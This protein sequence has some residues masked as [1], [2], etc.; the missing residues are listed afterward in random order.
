MPSRLT[1]SALSRDDQRGHVAHN[2]V[3]DL[4]RIELDACG[5]AFAIGRVDPDHVVALVRA[6]AEPG[7]LALAERD[8]GGAR[9]DHER[10]GRP[11]TRPSV[12]KCPF[13]DG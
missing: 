10:D 7:G 3:A 13:S 8:L 1:P 6:V 4:D 12:A 11:S 5:A 2:D 9:V